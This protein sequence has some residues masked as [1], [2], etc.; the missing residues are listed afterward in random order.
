MVRTCCKIRLSATDQVEE[1]GQ[2]SRNCAVAGSPLT[3]PAQVQRILKRLNA[4]AEV[5]SDMLPP[6]ERRLT[7]S[8]AQIQLLRT[9]GLTWRQIAIGLPSWKQKD[10]TA[11][12]DDQL[13]GAVSRI[14]A[15]QKPRPIFLEPP[16][17]PVHVK[18]VLAANPP[19]V[20]ISR[21]QVPPSEPSRLSSQLALTIK[22]RKPV[23]D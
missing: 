11:I 7:H 5:S 2:A 23:D 18:T 10:G 14:R 3:T 20:E 1:F 6:L 21:D 19:P 22:S 17:A 9:W 8:L 12:S 4:T 13:R 16:H 15:G